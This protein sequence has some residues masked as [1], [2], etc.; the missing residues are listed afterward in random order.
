MSGQ[1][2]RS[3]DC[4]ATRRWWI[5]AHASFEE[6]VKGTITPGKLADLVVP[7]RD[8]LS[9][10]PEQIEKIELVYTIIGGQVAYVRG[11]QASILGL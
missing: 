9:T 1:T 3:M 7:S 2:T 5:S 10:P 4:A 8:I 11:K 6:N